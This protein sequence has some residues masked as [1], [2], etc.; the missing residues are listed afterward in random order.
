MSLET[1]VETIHGDIRS[2]AKFV[3]GTWQSSAEVTKDRITEKSLRTE[4]FY[5]NNHAL[6]DIEENDAFL[7]FG[8]N[9]SSIFRKETIGN[10]F[11]QL[12]N[13]GWGCYKPFD[14]DVA[15]AKETSLKLRISD[16]ELKFETESDNYGYIEID[17]NDLTGSRLNDTQ[18]KFAEA[19]YG[20]MEVDAKGESDYS[21]AMHMLSDNGIMIARIYAFRKESVLRAA[22]EGVVVRSCRLYC[23]SGSSEFHAA[24]RGVDT[25]GGL[26]GVLES[27]NAQN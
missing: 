25:H 3:P 5:T 16:L 2:S 9:D 8:S 11:N 17:T 20:G 14:T 6:Y 13:T 18:R 21:R 4:W 10:A 1:S 23:F 22:K 26:R 19:V 15:K 27:D 24:I 12:K 7:Y